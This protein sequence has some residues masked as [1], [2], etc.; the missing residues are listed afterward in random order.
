M[1]SL[2]ASEQ[3]SLKEAVHE[4]PAGENGH[5]TQH[6]SPEVSSVVLGGAGFIRAPLEA[7]EASTAEF[8]AQQQSAHAEQHATAQLTPWKCP[9]Q[10]AQVP[11]DPPDGSVMAP[12]AAAALESSSAAAADA[13]HGILVQVAVARGEDTTSFVK[14]AL[15]DPSVMQVLLLVL[16]STLA[17][18]INHVVMSGNT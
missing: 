5:P 10:A 16:L 12:E 9:A 11:L 4:D 6:T 7:S 8:A 13:L 3:A 17:C 2:A 14:K 15:K 1:Q 18:I